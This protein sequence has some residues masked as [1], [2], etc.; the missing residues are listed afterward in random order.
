MQ[1]TVK[2][3]IFFLN[4]VQ[5]VHIFGKIF[6]FQ[7]IFAHNFCGWWKC[8]VLIIRFKKRKKKKI[9]LMIIKIFLEPE[10]CRP[11]NKYWQIFTF[12]FF[13]VS[14]FNELII[15]WWNVPIFIL[16][17]KNF[18]RLF[19][20]AFYVKIFMIFERNKKIWFF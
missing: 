18:I 3:I 17:N 5:C 12:Y 13:L 20:I 19:C 2:L 16:Y 1:R 15:Y 6:W 4:I 9:L 14:L 10:L 11:F 7:I 8:H